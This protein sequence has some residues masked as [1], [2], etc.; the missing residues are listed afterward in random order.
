MCNCLFTCW[1][2]AEEIFL[3]AIGLKRNASITVGVT[4]YITTT[5]DKTRQNKTTPTQHNEE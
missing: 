3:W 4:E 5:Q 2:T 1:R